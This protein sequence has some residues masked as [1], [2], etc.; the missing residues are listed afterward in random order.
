MV[1]TPTGQEWGAGLSS[2]PPP[3]CCRVRRRVLGVSG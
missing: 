2:S 1:G 3:A